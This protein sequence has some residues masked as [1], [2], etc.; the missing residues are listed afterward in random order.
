M[1]SNEERETKQKKTN[2]ADVIQFSRA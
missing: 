1:K 2:I